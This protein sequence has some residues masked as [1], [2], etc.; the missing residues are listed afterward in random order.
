[1]PSL[2]PRDPP[3]EHDRIGPDERTVREAIAS[4]RRGRGTPKEAAGNAAGIGRRYRAARAAR[5]ATTGERPRVVVGCWELAHNAAGRGQILAGLH[6][7]RATGVEIRILGC[8]FDRFGTEVWEPL[9]SLAMPPVHAI[10]AGYDDAGLPGR[11]LDLVLDHPCDLVHL[12]KP[13]MPNILLGLAARAVWGAAVIVDLDDEELAFAGAETAAD[14]ESILAAGGAARLPPLV[15]LPKSEWTRFAVAM[16]GEFDGV[17]VVN[18]PLRGRYGGTIIRHAR[19]VPPPE[20]LAVSRE[21]ERAGL[22]IASDR[23]VV[24]F[25]GTPRPH[26]GLV[27]TASMIARAGCPAAMFLVIGDFVDPDLRRSLEGV[28][29]VEVRLLGN[30]PLERLPSLVAACDVHVSLL[31]DAS[32]VS[33]FQTP[34]KL[35]DALAGGLAVVGR[36]S[37]GTAD[38]L[39]GV[40]GSAATLDELGVELARLLRDP[41]ARRERGRAGRAWYERHLTVEANARTL[42]GLVRTVLAKGPGSFRAGLADGLDL[43]LGRMLVGPGPEVRTGR[44]VRG[45]NRPGHASDSGTDRRERA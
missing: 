24:G 10:A 28:P 45:P 16:A 22:G 40:G 15:R 29:G 2:P 27:E 17:T 21:D 25:L 5:L 11:L 39:D 33:A 30:Q 8:L 38:I 34:A 32:K 42:D 20:R 4:I 36:P 26:K 35:T 18:E 9:R 3:S 6:A 44:G 23:V 37:P 19:D 41:A 1:M 31:D 12:S 13:R 14:L 7:A 43:L